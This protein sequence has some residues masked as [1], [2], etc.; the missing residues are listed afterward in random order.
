M[1]HYQLSQ[2]VNQQGQGRLDS[3]WYSVTTFFLILY[4]DILS[5]AFT[6]QAHLC[7]IG[8]SEIA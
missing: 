1:M 2:T 6:E 5:T 4:S 8:I 7:Q 3:K